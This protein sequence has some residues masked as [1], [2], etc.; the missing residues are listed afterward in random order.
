MEQMNS[1]GRSA[2]SKMHVTGFLVIHSAPA[3]LRPHIEWGLQSILGTWVCLEWKNQPHAPGTFRT[4]LEFRDRIG[5]GA[6][7]AT[8]LKAW[9]YLR[10]EMREESEIGGEFF[11]FTPELG[12]HR[13]DIDGAGSIMI[14][15][16]LITS[17]L[18]KA[19]DEES[20]REEFERI[21]GNQWELA[22]KPFRGVELGEVMALRAI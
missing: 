4:T 7:I 6:K 8:A 20:L 15:E 16:H 22:L 9:H 10:F 13:S 14:S 3:A 1:S 11:R 19:F 18:A 2:L 12:I 17:S 21:L 5:T